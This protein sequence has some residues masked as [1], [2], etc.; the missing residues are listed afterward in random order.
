MALQQSIPAFKANTGSANHRA[1]LIQDLLPLANSIVCRAARKP[2]DTF[3]EDISLT[4]QQLWELEA[5]Y[6]NQ[7]HVVAE[8]VIEKVIKRDFVYQDDNTLVAYAGTALRIDIK[9]DFKSKVW[10]A[11]EI[12]DGVSPQ[13]RKVVQLEDPACD[14]EPF[15]SETRSDF[16]ASCRESRLFEEMTN[17]Q[18]D[19]KIL[20]AMYFDHTQYI[21]HGGISK[22]GWVKLALV[23]GLSEQAAEEIARLADYSTKIKKRW[24]Q[25]AKQVNLNADHLRR[26]VN[27]KLRQPLDSD[28]RLFDDVMHQIEKECNE[29]AL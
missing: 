9:A 21:K 11:G 1:Q 24:V 10:K 23:A 25:F 13:T 27:E 15:E 2:S 22:E 26:T 6:K 16:I 4:D 3:K 18:V 12:P 29:N 8:V 19:R 5:T 28:E 20:L 7:P 14:R 17:T